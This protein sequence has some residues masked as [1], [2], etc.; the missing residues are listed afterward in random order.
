MSGNPCHSELG[1]GGES[2]GAGSARR[3]GS[4][5]SDGAARN[6]SRYAFQNVPKKPCDIG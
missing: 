5:S 3:G 2:R 1:N 4:A 6:S